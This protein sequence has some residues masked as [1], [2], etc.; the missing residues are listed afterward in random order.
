MTTTQYESKCDLSEIKGEG[1]YHEAMKHTNPEDLDYMY[2][3]RRKRDEPC[4]I[5]PPSPDLNSSYSDCPCDMKF[6]KFKV[7]ENEILERENRTVDN[8]QILNCVISMSGLDGL[9]ILDELMR[10]GFQITLIYWQ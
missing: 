10:Q 6:V 2:Q 4:K 8:E 1:C 9:D 3:V 7:G 5:F